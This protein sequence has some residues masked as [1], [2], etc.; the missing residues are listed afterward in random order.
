MMRVVSVDDKRHDQLP[1]D[2]LGAAVGGAAY[3]ARP[4]PADGYATLPPSY[5][6][7]LYFLSY[8]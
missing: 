5:E 6:L 2:A 7:W 1:L 8:V 3:R 4:A